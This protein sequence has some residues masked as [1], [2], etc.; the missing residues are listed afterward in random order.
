MASFTRDVVGCRKFYRWAGKR[1]GVL[2]P[3][4]EMEYGRGR[5]QENV[6]CLDPAAIRR[7][8]DLGVR[9]RGLDGRVDRQWRGRND[10][11]DGAFVDGLYG[12]GLRLSSLHV[13][14]GR[15]VRQ[16]RLRLHLLDAAGGGVVS[17]RLP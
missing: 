15:S 12:T 5:R 2:D 6:K 9:G 7:W 8:R 4:D 10:Q 11:R 13:L 1:Y 17:A 16:G 14:A 3:F